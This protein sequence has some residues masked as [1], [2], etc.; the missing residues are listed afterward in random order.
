VTLF[1]LGAWYLGTAS[2]RAQT[3][4][5]DRELATI[6]MTD[7]EARIFKS[8]RDEESRKAFIDEFWKVRDPDPST[9]ANEAKVEFDLRVEYAN[10]WFSF[11]DPIRGRDVS[12]RSHPKDG[13]FSSRGQIYIILGPADRL[14][15]WGSDWL[16]ESSRLHWYRNPS[17]DSQFVEEAWIY[18][19]LALIVNFY[20]T[21]SGRW[22]LSPSGLLPGK[23]EDAK[24]SLLAGGA[25]WASA[26]P[27]RFKAKFNDDALWIE[28]PV[29]RVTFDDSWRASFRVTVTVYR[30]MKKIG[31][32][33]ETKSFAESVDVLDQKKNLTFSIPYRPE[34]PGLYYFAIL[35]EDVMARSET[36]S[37]AVV[38]VRRK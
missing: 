20:K 14:E 6:I 31:Q 33:E 8:L 10:A 23:L 15:L 5:P 30:E 3:A 4:K 22:E 17:D 26:Q 1:V 9:E 25:G 35:L 28:I 34:T 7:D 29:K 38:E 36:R 32:I 19:G 11:R 21:D 13:C 37:R 16:Y 2:I 24:L 27:F 12:G 18:D